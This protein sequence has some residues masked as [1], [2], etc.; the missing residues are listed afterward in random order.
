MNSREHKPA[1]EGDKDDAALN[2]SR[3]FFGGKR[4]MKHALGMP[5]NQKLS[6]DDFHAYQSFIINTM[7]GSGWETKCWVQ[8]YIPFRNMLRLS[9]KHSGFWL[10]LKQKFEQDGMWPV[11]EKR[12]ETCVL[13]FFQGGIRRTD[14]HEFREEDQYNEDSA[15]DELECAECRGLGD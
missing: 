4:L 6:D 7:S 14:W 11:F 3:M 15:Q 13:A 5:Q 9:N 10:V 2:Q 1:A 8:D 12:D